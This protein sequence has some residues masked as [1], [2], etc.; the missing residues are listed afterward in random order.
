MA[1][2]KMA[3]ILVFHGRLGLKHRGRFVITNRSADWC[4]RTAE[5][6]PVADEARRWG[7]EIRSSAK[8]SSSSV[9]AYRSL[10]PLAKAYSLRPSSSP[11]K[12]SHFRGPHLRRLYFWGKSVIFCEVQRIATLRSQWH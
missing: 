4:G 11:Q 12:C 6:P 5:V 9:T 10:T 7:E 8:H 3:A 2:M 1:V